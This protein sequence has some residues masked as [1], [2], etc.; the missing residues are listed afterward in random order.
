M[1]DIRP[2]LIVAVVI[3]AVGII[4]SV[5]FFN[6][7]K[8]DDVVNVTGLGQRDFSA[9]LI[10]WESSFRRSDANLVKAYEKLENDKKLVSDYLLS[11]GVK[12]SEVI[13]KPVN[14][15][16]QYMNFYDGDNNLVGRKLSGYDLS[17]TYR[18]DSRDVDTIEL[19][20]RG[21]TELIK[22]GIE[23]YSES[24]DY[25]Y[26]GLSD[27]KVELIALATKDARTRAEKIAEQSGS[28][29]GKVRY[30][31]MGVFQIIGL[32]DSPESNWEGSFDTKSRAKTATITVRLQYE[33]R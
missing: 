28:K 30:A 29:L 10:S 33:L 4:F 24:P 2:V 14:I 23:V 16:E 9:D 18:I 32:N 5:T 20:S 8:A 13:Y 26:S 12:A 22:A 15:Q 25:F 17:Q 11:K 6:R 7:A 31:N 1:K 3:F 27:L 21:I 19:A